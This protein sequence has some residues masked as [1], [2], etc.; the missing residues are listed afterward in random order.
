MEGCCFACTESILL[1][2]MTEISSGKHLFSPDGFM[3]FVWVGLPHPGSRSGNSQAWLIGTFYPLDHSY[4]SRNGHTVYM[5][6]LRAN[7]R[8]FTGMPPKKALWFQKTVSNKDEINLNVPGAT[9]LGRK[10]MPAQGKAKW[11]RENFWKRSYKHLNQTGPK[12]NR[13]RTF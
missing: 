1:S 5:G 9:P 4:Y 10:T 6:P 3:G 11:Q 7:T 2:F 12:G 13:V 8:I